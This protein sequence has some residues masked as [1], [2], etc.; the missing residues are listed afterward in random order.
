[1]EKCDCQDWSPWLTGGDVRTEGLRQG[2][3]ATEEGLHM[4]IILEYC[5]KCSLAT[6]LKIQKWCCKGPKW[7]LDWQ[8]AISGSIF[9]CS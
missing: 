4:I 9:K 8:R 7:F 2:T 3:A 1:M 6:S 5:I